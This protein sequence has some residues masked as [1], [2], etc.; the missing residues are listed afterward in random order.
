LE[1]C[2]SRRLTFNNPPLKYLVFS[3]EEEEVWE[4][5]LLGK[6]QEECSLSTSLLFFKMIVLLVMQFK[7]MCLYPKHF[8][9]LMELDL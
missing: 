9:H 7:A 3:L 8:K 1:T 6:G 4:K 5:V 2:P